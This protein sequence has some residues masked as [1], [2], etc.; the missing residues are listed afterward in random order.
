MKEYQFEYSS[1]I[2][3]LK[4]LGLTFSPIFGVIFLSW[5]FRAFVKIKV[6]GVIPVIISI[7][8]AILLFNL[9]KKKCKR[10]GIAYLD[11]DKIEFKLGETAEKINFQSIN[12]YK[13]LDVPQAVVLTLHYNDYLKLKIKANYHFANTLKLSELCKDLVPS[14]EKFKIANHSSLVGEK[15]FL[16]KKW[17]LALIILLTLAAI[18]IMCISFELKYLPVKFF[19]MIGGVS[20][21][22]IQYFQQ[23]K[24]R[25]LED[26]SIEKLKQTNSA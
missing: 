22:W 23:R 19:A 7:A 21:V 6:D 10:Y 13:I 14:L 8:T 17:Y 5:F 26:E 18:V 16:E 20:V 3:I 12:S 9:F 25:R 11:D 1:N 24:K 2:S 15:T 4:L